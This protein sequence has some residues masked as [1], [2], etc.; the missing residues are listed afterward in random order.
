MESR[1]SPKDREDICEAFR[2]PIGGPHQNDVVQFLIIN[3]RVGGEGLNL[4]S[5]HRVHLLEPATTV[6]AEVQVFGRAARSGQSAPVVTAS[7]TYS[8]DGWNPID[9]V[10]LTRRT[11]TERMTIDKFHEVFEAQPTQQADDD[12]M[13]IA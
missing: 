1:T 5:T 11:M 10:M 4:V 9:M 8:T 7:T 6:D 12:V 2:I 3:R 13:E